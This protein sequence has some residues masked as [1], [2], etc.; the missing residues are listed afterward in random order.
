MLENPTVAKFAIANHSAYGTAMDHTLKTFVDN[1][2]GTLTN[3][4]IRGIIDSKPQHLM[5]NPSTFSLLFKDK[6]NFNERNP[7]TRSI[8][9][10]GRYCLERDFRKKSQ[11]KKKK[12]LRQKRSGEFDENN[13]LICKDEEGNITSTFNIGADGKHINVEPEDLGLINLFGEDNNEINH[14]IASRQ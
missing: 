12:K 13:N 11:K 10:F 9:D 3:I 6:Y 1:R 7:K 8:L 2:G 14:P 4:T 5:E